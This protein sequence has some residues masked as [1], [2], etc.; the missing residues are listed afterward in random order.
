MHRPELP[1]CARLGL[2]SRILGFNGRFDEATH[3]MND[4]LS[5]P[6]VFLQKLLYAITLVL[7]SVPEEQ[8]LDGQY[9][10][11]KRRMLV[12]PKNR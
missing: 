4:S 11:L 6:V 12:R 5:N 3:E 10:I 9:S 2:R 8:L 7:G 1:Q